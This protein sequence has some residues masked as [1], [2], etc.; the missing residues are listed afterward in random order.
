MYKIYFWRKPS[1]TI[2]NCND[3]LTIVDCNS[4]TILPSLILLHKRYNSI[5]LFVIKHRNIQIYRASK[6]IF[7][8]LLCVL[9][10]GPCIRSDIL[11]LDVYLDG[12]LKL[13]HWDMRLYLLDGY[14]ILYH[15]FSISGHPCNLNSSR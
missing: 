12:E 1:Y 2:D 9:Y 11:D 3:K 5:Q 4:P 6:H 8:L 13:P 10:S 7:S 15:I 14:V